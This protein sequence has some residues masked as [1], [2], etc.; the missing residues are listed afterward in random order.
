MAEAYAAYHEA[1]HNGPNIAAARL[2][3]S[4]AEPVLGR[5]YALMLQWVERDLHMHT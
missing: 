3:F 1:S 2:T 4:L 5:E